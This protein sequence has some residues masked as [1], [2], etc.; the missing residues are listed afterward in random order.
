MR[1]G[2]WAPCTIPE[3]QATR[4]KHAPL[5]NA[6]VN[7]GPADAEPD[8]RLRENLLDWQELLVIFDPFLPHQHVIAG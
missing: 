6:Q 4:Y 7:N 8:Y 3:L 5:R 2:H 1:P